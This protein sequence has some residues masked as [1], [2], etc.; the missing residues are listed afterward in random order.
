[1]QSVDVIVIGGG[2]AGCE[3]AAAAARLGARTLLITL[4]ADNLGEMSC[5]P[6]FGGVGKG[7]IVREIDALD[8]V[9]ARI[10]DQAGIH[11][12]MLNESKGPAVWGP[13]AQADRALYRQAMRHELETTP[14]LTLLYTQVAEIC[15]TAS[16]VTG[17]KLADGRTLNA[18]AVVLTTGTFLGG[19]IHIGPQSYPAGRVNEPASITL[20]QSLL[21]HGFTVGRLKTG[22]PPR[23]LKQSIDW[24]GLEIQHGNLPPEPLSLLTTRVE[25]PQ[26][27]CHITA[28]NVATHD[29]VRNNLQY[30]AMY[31]GFI[32]GRGPR[33]CPSIEDKIT[34]FAE[35]QQHQIFL[36]P[37]GLNSDLIYP[38]G[39]STSLP[40][41]IQ[42]QF[43]RTIHGLERVEM[44]QPGYAIEYDYIDPRQ[45]LPTL[46]AKRVQRLFFAG[47]IN[48]TTGY[49]EAGGQ[50]LVAGINAALTAAGRMNS[51]IMSRADGYIGIMIDDLITRGV[52]EPYRM[53]TS[54][55]E[56]RMQHRSDNADRRLT[57]SGY[58]L[59]C[60][61][62]QRY[63][64]LQ[65]KLQAYEQLLSALSEVT[66]LPETLAKHG[67][68]ITRDGVKRTAHELLALPQISLENVAALWPELGNYP[69]PLQQTMRADS[70]YASYLKRQDEDLAA[71]A[72][73]EKIVL[74]VQI[75]YYQITGLSRE[76]MDRLAAALPA[77]LAQARNLEGITPTAIVSILAHLKKVSRGT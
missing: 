2:H 13:R 11:Y 15:S 37:E 59:G 58:H 5:N 71:L 40:A 46:E 69:L 65:A 48:G 9:M 16:E 1:M 67:H 45:L 63:Q 3:A 66:F 64:Q 62:V 12:R 51:Y 42:L 54:R 56:Y 23:L 14:N 22:T 60:V 26:I 29:V 20:S 75:D 8:G 28:T 32:T 10:V 74:P 39:I 6:A 7:I 50:G 34:R 33:Y 4:A 27:P 36:E 55:N 21:K 31:G 18:G 41:T 38:N 76:V 72:Q 52:T 43:L 57:E 53:L 17:V 47:Q 19:M 77:T 25:V 24:A 35:K 73:L 70:L 30:S 44:A 68:K 61:S 49:E